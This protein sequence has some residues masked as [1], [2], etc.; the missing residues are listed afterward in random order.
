MQA[1]QTPNVLKAVN[2]VV[3]ALLTVEDIKTATKYV[4]KKLTVRGTWNKEDVGIDR[5]TISLSIGAPNYAER[6][7]IQACVKVGEPFPVRRVQYRFRKETP[8]E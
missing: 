1:H 8:H 2:A 7:F 3:D 4:N 5:R 6:E